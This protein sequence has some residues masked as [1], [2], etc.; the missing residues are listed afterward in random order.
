LPTLNEL[1]NFEIQLK[2]QKVDQGYEPGNN[3]PN[4]EEYDNHE[5]RN[6]DANEKEEL[7]KSAKQAIETALNQDPK[8]SSDELSDSN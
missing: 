6:K 5:D 8:V 3:N 2:R 1:L 7:R 4:R